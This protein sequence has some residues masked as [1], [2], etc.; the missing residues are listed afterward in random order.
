MKKEHFIEGLLSEA[1]ESRYIIRLE[2][3]WRNEV[4]RVS[5]FL[6]SAYEVQYSYIRHHDT[7]GITFFLNQELPEL[8]DI[9]TNEFPQ[10]EWVHHDGCDLFILK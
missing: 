4:G 7:T 10:G 2:E 1:R 9:F 5:D 6:R 8:K 3:K